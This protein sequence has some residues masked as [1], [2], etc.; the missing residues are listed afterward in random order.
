MSVFEFVFEGAERERVAACVERR[1]RIDLG[2]VASEP[3]LLAGRRTQ[4]RARKARTHASHQTA[5]RQPP[6]NTNTNTDTDTLTLSLALRLEDVEGG[7]LAP[8]GEVPVP[9]RARV[10]PRLAARSMDDR[11]DLARSEAVL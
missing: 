6:S 1:R 7:R 2:T 3:R 4:R 11:A 8:A 10:S 5:C 9:H